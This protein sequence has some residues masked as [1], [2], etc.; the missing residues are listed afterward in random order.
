MPV[1]AGCPDC[2]ATLTV[3]DRLVG[4]HVKCSKCKSVFKVPPGEIDRREPIPEGADR[5]TAVIKCP[6]CGQEVVKEATTCYH[7]RAP[8]R[9]TA[10]ARH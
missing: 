9:R 10:K 6:A 2:W 7:C 4:K 5:E 1:Y 8:I 3:P